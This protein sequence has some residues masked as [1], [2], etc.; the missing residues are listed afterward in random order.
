LNP[1]PASLARLTLLTGLASTH[2]TLLMRAGM[3][4]FSIMAALSWLGGGLLLVEQED[5]GGVLDLG[6]IPRRRW[7]PAVLLLLWALL[8]LSFAARLYDPLLHLVPV[9]ALPGL[10]LAY[11][12]RWR[13]R[14][15]FELTMIALLLPA[16]V[17]INRFLPTGQLADLTARVSAFL[18]WLIGQ[19]AFPEGDRIV[20]QEQTLVV[21]ASCTGVNTMALCIAAALLLALLIPPPPGGWGR[22]AK[23]AI[24]A[25]LSLSLAFGVNA[26]RVALLG[27]TTHDPPKAWYG[28]LVSFDFWHDGGGSHLFSLTAMGL[29]C[30][31]YVLALELALRQSRARHRRP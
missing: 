9:A 19:P 10:A 29:V 15:V 2:L 17:L 1:Q 12:V 4:P 21:D 26:I 5:S 6:R 7:I 16:Q 8:V 20:I 24:M 11:G 31:L 3:A 18:L 27:L 14:Q 25:A 23:V 30:G 22:S 28:S 13:S